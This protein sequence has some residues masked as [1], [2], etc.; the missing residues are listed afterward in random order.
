LSI[1]EMNIMAAAQ[2][3]PHP[4]PG[5]DAASGAMPTVVVV[6]VGRRVE[7]VLPPVDLVDGTVVVTSLEGVTE[8]SWKMPST[9]WNTTMMA[10]EF[11]NPSL[12]VPVPWPPD[13]ASH[14][15][16][17]IPVTVAAPVAHPIV[18]VVGRICGVGVGPQD[19]T[20]G[21]ELGV[22]VL[23]RVE[24]VVDT[25]PDVVEEWGAVDSVGGEDFDPT[26][27]PMA[28]PTPS[29]TSTRAAM[30]TRT[31]VL[32]RTVISRESLFGI[33]SYGTSQRS[34]N[35]EWQLAPSQREPH[36]GMPVF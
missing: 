34:R 16:Q 5:C 35:D 23:V 18:S 27:N 28:V 9:T 12:I 36:V 21:T 31:T 19:S 11:R 25:G 14:A 33:N 24:V 10:G 1:D 8:M 22:V 20:A 2:F 13:A 32:R 29:A 15:F 7:V 4:E 30:P 26:A 3:P 17:V 6:V